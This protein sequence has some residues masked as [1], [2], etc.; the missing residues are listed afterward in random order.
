MSLP[1]AILDL[2]SHVKLRAPPLLH[3]SFLALS[4]LL[5]A[6]GDLR[7]DKSVVPNW[8][9]FLKQLQLTN[10]PSAQSIYDAMVSELLALARNAPGAVSDFPF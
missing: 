8:A 4:I 3:S 6:M 5:E 9:Q 10:S 7:L 1:P 2:A